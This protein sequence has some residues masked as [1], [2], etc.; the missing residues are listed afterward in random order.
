MPEMPVS[1]WRSFG[2]IEFMMRLFGSAIVGP[3]P[4]R[5][6]H[7]SLLLGGWIEPEN[8][9]ALHDLLGDELLECRHLHSLGGDFVGKMGRDHDDALGIADHD[10]ARPYGNVPASDRHVDIECLVEREVRGS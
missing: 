9:A 4:S 5:E 10:V 8:R 6:I 1:A 7:P 2:S 3:P